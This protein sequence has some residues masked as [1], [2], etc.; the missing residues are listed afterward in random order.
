MTIAIL[1]KRV[2]TLTCVLF[3]RLNRPHQGETMV[4]TKKVEEERDSAPKIQLLVGK[5]T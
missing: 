5:S 2:I 1:M 4:V 3:G